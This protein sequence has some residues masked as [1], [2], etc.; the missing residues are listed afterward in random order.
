MDGEVVNTEMAAA[1]DGHEGDMWTDHADRYDRANRRIRQRLLDT[2]QVGRGDRA[3]DLGCGTGDATRVVARRAPDGQITGI[4]LSTRM[5]DLARQRSAAER[6]DNVTFVR[7]DAQVHPFEPGAFDLVF[8]SFGGMFFSDPVAAFTN[9]AR[10]LRPGGSLALLTW[11]SLPENEWLVA[12]RGAVALGRDL[13][14]PPPDAP[15]PFALADP[16][17]V[18]A[19]LGSAGFDQLELAPIDEPVDLGVDAADAFEFAKSMGVVEGLTDG[20]DESARAEAM[21]NLADL[22]REHESPDGVLI[23][24]AAWLITARREG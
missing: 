22:L 20:L 4:D 2:L 7:G 16:E 1:W 15:T 10:G 6:L 17:R 24:T 14:V 13:P 11:R 9:I 21:S 8:S 12:L 5:L 23:G 19:I 3:L 18:R